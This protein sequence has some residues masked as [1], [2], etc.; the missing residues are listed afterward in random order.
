MMDPGFYQDIS[1]HDYLADSAINNS[2]LKVFMQSPAK[3][4][5]W[6]ENQKPGTTTQLEGS[7]LHTKI[8]TPNLF[9]KEF[10]KTAALRTGSAA[11]VKWDRMNPTAM[12][13]SPASWAR[14]HNMTEAFAKTDYTVAKELLSG[15]LPEL[16]IFFDDPVT[17]LRC[18]IRPD[19]LK[20]DNIIIDIKSTQAGS[21]QGFLREVRR[22]G[23]DLQASFYIRGLNVA[24]RA[25][26]V[27]RQAQAFLFVAIE[28]FPPHEVAVYALSE[29]MLRE[30]GERIDAALAAY[31]ICLETDNWP[32]YAN[33]V[34]VLG[35]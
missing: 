19:Y 18:K 26:G 25:A 4:K 21:P 6:S 32:G 10:G 7:A 2:S 23:Y 30:A 5:Y 8:L 12:A 33:G 34:V 14:V 24:Y 27:N 17:D 20:D 13:L 31:K 15:G 9:E 3:S 28:N 1:F 35:E 16:S 11:R 22:W 29:D